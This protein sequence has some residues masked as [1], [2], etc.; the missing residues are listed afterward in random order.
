MKKR[1][2]AI[3]CAISAL[4]LLVGC[5]SAEPT[6]NELENI[7]DFSV[8][9]DPYNIILSFMSNPDD[10]YGK[11]IKINATSS[12]VYNFVQNKA[13]THIMLG[14]DPTGC[15]NSY[16]EVKH[17]KNEYPVNGSYTTFIGTFTSDN[18]IDLHSWESVSSNEP[19]YGIDTLTM[20]ADELN[21]FIT[22]YTENALDSES[23]G[24]KVRIFGHH[25]VYNG[26]KFLFGVDAQGNAT[27]NIELHDPTGELTFPTV[28]GNLINPVEIIGTLSV[29]YEGETYY[30]CI[31]VEQVN[32]VECV[33]S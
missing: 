12:V 8:L 24:K 33:F 3:M 7:V 5:S 18:Y 32:K 6:D 31:E 14:L 25:T 4:C 28:S 21:Q 22:E 27:W 30:A 20:T 13:D 10:Y 23:S 16:F 26:Y 1:I 11:N 9:D 2:L 29:Y 19:N 17:P 15:C